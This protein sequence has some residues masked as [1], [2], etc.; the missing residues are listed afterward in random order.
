MQA[1]QVGP[2]A[3]AELAAWEELAAPAGLVVRGERQVPRN[4]QPAAIAAIGSTI[5]NIAA[6]LHIRTEPRQIGL[7]ERRGATPLPTASRVRA[8]RSADRAETFPVTAAEV[9]V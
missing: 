5:L 1:E 3:S 4:C 6:V 7:A 8:S 9:P 2:A